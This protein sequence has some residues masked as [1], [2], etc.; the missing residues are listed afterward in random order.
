MNPEPV[1]D[2]MLGKGAVGFSWSQPVSGGGSTYDVLRSRDAMEWYDATCVIT[3]AS[4]TFGVPDPE[5]PAPGELF[6]YL[7]GAHSPCGRS[8]FGLNVDDTPRHG[9]ACDE[10]MSWWE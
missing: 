3:G 1:T 6:L 9:T 5:D 8:T 10:G 2:L 7:V 4:Q